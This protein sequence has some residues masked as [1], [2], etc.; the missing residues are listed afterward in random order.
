MNLE[1]LPASF[2]PKSWYMKKIKDDDIG[3]PETI[4]RVRKHF[5]LATSGEALLLISDEAKRRLGEVEWLK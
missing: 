2:F 1:G 4:E 3:K 5:G